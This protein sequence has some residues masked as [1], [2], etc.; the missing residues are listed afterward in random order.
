MI[1]C[2]FCIAMIY[3]MEFLR[4]CPTLDQAVRQADEVRM[5]VFTGEIVV[6][7]F[8]II[9]LIYSKQF[10]DEEKAERDRSFII[11]L[12]WK[13]ITLDRNVS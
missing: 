10:S 2:I 12:D 3:M 9:F 13:E 8:C 4:D 11:F 1:T 7:I 5:I 6:E